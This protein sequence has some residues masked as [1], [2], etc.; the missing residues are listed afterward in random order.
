MDFSNCLRTAHFTLMQ[1]VIKM[2]VTLKVGRNHTDLPAIQAFTEAGFTII[3]WQFVSAGVEENLVFM[4][5]SRL[6]KDQQ[7]DREY[8]Q[9]GKNDICNIHVY[10]FQKEM[11]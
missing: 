10:P 5:A 9:K 8:P 6:S 7:Q 2:S 4:L 11:Y 3:T 1:I